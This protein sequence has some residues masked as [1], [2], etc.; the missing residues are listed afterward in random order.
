ML[1]IQVQDHYGVTHNLVHI[2][3]QCICHALVDQVREYQEHIPVNYVS[4]ATEST[5]TR[6]QLLYIYFPF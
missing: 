2:F 1:P 5:S 3:G 4:S 6:V